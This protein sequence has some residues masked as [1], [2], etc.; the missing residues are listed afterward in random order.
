MDVGHGIQRKRRKYVCRPEGQL[1]PST[2]MKPGRSRTPFFLK[3]TGLPY[4]STRRRTKD[5]GLMKGFRA[6]GN[7]Q[8]ARSLRQ[9]THNR[10]T[11]AAAFRTLS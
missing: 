1:L 6:A 4:S 9:S 3:M 7:W 11:I 8:G 5:K 2:A 10:E